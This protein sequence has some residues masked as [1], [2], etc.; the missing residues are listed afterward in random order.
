MLHTL[1]K[2]DTFFL[3]D[4]ETLSIYSLDQEQ[5][6]RFYNI[7][8]I[9][10]T[11]ALQKNKSV[12]KKSELVEDNQIASRLVL[13]ITQSCN[14]ACRYCYAHQGTYGASHTAPMNLSMLQLAVK[15][16][17]GLYPKGIE[18]IQF[19]G[20]EPLLNFKLIEKGVCWIEEYFDSLG[21]QMPLF[22]FVTNGVLFSEYIHRFCNEHRVNVTVSIDGNKEIN[23][24]NRPFAVGSGSSYDAI[25]KSMEII[26][27][28]RKY[29]LMIE[30]T[31]SKSNI[32]QYKKTKHLI[33]I[34]HLMEFRPDV[35]HIVPVINASSASKDYLWS[36]EEY[37]GV[38][39]YFE[40]VAE[41]SIS[42]LF[43]GN[44]L[45]VMQISN[46]GSLLASKRSKSLLCTAGIKEISITPS[47]DVYPCFAFIGHDEMKMG[48]I[49]EDGDL[50]QSP[51]YQSIRSRLESN[52]YS[53]IE[54][55]QQCWLNGLCANCIGNS[56][57]VNGS[58]SDPIDV[59]C[60]AQRAMFERSLCNCG[61]LFGIKE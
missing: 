38:S 59:I 28:N 25:K 37:R 49:L 16:T 12:N 53:H 32:D 58:I 20:G 36:E 61:E 13:V 35:F 10:L 22:N 24:Y 27:N 26:A 46:I 56:Y 39:E 18:K 44:P 11:K 23:D 60:H 45:R 50:R 41:K 14:L 5:G 1:K 57:D 21:L 42:S 17:L 40:E 2:Q 47:G 43:S 8:D 29:D 48:N 54:K 33:D 9:E 7:G 31:I 6:Q 34:E 4:N 19:F 30:M 52:T 15:S 55:C 51:R 3:F